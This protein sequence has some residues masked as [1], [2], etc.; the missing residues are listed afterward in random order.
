MKFEELREI[1]S[2]N[3]LYAVRVESGVIVSSGFLSESILP[4]QGKHTGAVLLYLVNGKVESGFALRND[5]FVTSLRA[6]EEM[7]VQAGLAF[8]VQPSRL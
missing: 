1:F 2:E 8:I 3:G 4:G 5:E 7:R 6:L